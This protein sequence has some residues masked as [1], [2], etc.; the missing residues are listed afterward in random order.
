MLVDKNMNQGGALFPLDLIPHGTILFVDYDNEI[1]TLSGGYSTCI[2]QPTEY[3]IIPVDTDEIV[4]LYDPFNGECVPDGKVSNFIKS[5]DKSQIIHTGC[6]IIIDELSSFV[7]DSSNYV[8]INVYT[9][10]I[11]K[12]YIEVICHDINKIDYSKVNGIAT[13][14]ELACHQAD[15]KYN[16][17]NEVK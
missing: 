4:V 8:K 16:R 1:I 12:N 14:Q 7:K 11:K 2:L 9:Q 17:I 13:E 15:K 6:K 10:V 5:V 3:Q